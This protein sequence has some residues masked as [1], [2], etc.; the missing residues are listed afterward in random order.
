VLA[1]ADDYVASKHGAA[2]VAFLASDDAM[3]VT[4]ADWLIDGGQTLQ[5]WANAP[6]GGGF[7]KFR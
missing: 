3:H 5:S 6:A 4:G 1:V 2:A 7:P